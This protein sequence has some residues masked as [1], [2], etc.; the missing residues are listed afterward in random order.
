MRYNIF[1]Y[2]HHPSKLFHSLK[3]ISGCN[4]WKIRSCRICCTFSFCI[5]DCLFKKN[6]SN[7]LLLLGGYNIYI[8]NNCKF[9][10]YFFP[11]N[12]HIWK[13][14]N[15]GIKFFVFTFL[16]VRI[17]NIPNMILCKLMWIV[18]CFLNAP[19]LFI[20]IKIKWIH[21][22]LCWCVFVTLLFIRMRQ[23]IYDEFSNI[24]VVCFYVENFKN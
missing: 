9:I 21:T 1:T 6:K 10:T 3:N 11:H 15:T 23:I 16:F 19:S 24:V 4:Y 12:F 8:G 2:K 5:I 18:R 14:M 13:E 20:K 17:F 22:L 7:L